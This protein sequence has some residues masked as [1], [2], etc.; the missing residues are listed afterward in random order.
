MIRSVDG[1]S[2]VG[3]DRVDIATNKYRSKGEVD[4]KILLSILLPVYNVEFYIEECLEILSYGLKLLPDIKSV[5]VVAVDDASTDNSNKILCDIL[6]KM[7]CP[8]QIIRHSENLGVSQARN[9]LLNLATGRYIW[10][11]D[12]DDKPDAM[13]IQLILQCISADS[14]DI[15]MFDWF[16]Q[17]ELRRYRRN[18]PL[19]KR[20]SAA[21]GAFGLIVNDPHEAAARVLLKDK[22]Y[23][24]NKVFKRTLAEDLVFPNQRYFEDIAFSTAILL[25]SR[26]TRYLSKALITYRH[27]EGSIVNAPSMSKLNDWRKGLLDLRV[28]VTSSAPIKKELVTAM[29]YCQ[30]NNYFDIIKGCCIAQQY[31]K[32]QQAYEEM[33]KTAFLSFRQLLFNL[34]LAAH[35][36][37]AIRI[38]KKMLIVKRCYGFH[39]FN[40]SYNCS[41]LK[42]ELNHDN[43]Y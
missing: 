14:P 43:E 34:V 10:F 25:K 37:T 13:A 24:W 18:K 28:V 11:V 36:V 12:P 2:G 33:L 7:G 19:I 30:F 26:A 41:W 6:G 3:E 8:T 32:A 31:A 27:R 22:L 23:L 38:Y 20:R 39:V 29:S 17:N 40:V 1:G 42:T 21:V 5:E 35:W 16:T 15:I 9:T 4:S